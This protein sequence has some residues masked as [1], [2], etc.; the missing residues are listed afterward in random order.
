M[1]PIVITDRD[2]RIIR[3]NPAYTQMTGYTAEELIN[4]TPRLLRSGHHD[5]A[6][7]QKMWQQIKKEGHWQGEI[8]NRRKNGGIYVEWLT[9]AAVKDNAGEVTH[10]VASAH[11]LTEQK[12]I[13]AEIEKLAFYDPLT[14]LP[15]RRLLRDRLE[16]SLVSL[17][18]EK[19]SGAL[20]FIDLDNFKTI[21]D[22]MGHAVG[23][24]LLVQIAGRLREVTRKS[25]TVARLGGDEFVVLLTNLDIDPKVAKTQAQH[26]A[27][28]ILRT[29]SQPYTL[30]GRSHNS[31]PSIGISMF[32]DHNQD[33]DQLLKQADIAMYQAKDAGHGTIRFFDPQTQQRLEKQV[34]MELALRD[35][36]EQGRLSYQLQ[37]IVNT[38]GKIVAAELLARWLQ[39]DGSNIPPSE[40]IP[41]A[42]KTGLII[43][44]GKWVLE[45]ACQLLANWQHQDR[46]AD[47]TLSV[48]VSARQLQQ[49]SDGK[50]L[51]DLLDRTRAPAHRLRL[52]FT[53]SSMMLQQYDTAKIF[54][55]LRNL[56]IE[57]ALDDFGTGFSSL[58]HL[59]Q[60][61]VTQLKI[62]QSFVRDL[63]TDRND[64]AIVEAILA[65]AHALDLTV[66]A[67][68]VE[69]N[70]QF[71]FL[72]QHQCDL[73]QGY[74]F[75]RPMS[76]AEFE[77]LVSQESSC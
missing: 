14:G 18:R 36:L 48:N 44:L 70:E 38:A 10:Y 76:T 20:L 28:K 39:L 64:A 50:V 12:K 24:Q 61:P 37:P 53:E 9:I 65:M 52:E 66:V 71:N 69:T 77:A 51:Q 32:H 72:R 34:H 55:D 16:H 26:V 42:E 3:V 21:N 58:C 17:A 43:P 67:E 15:N 73:Y 27:E 40:F 1:Q 46:L 68:G 22:T 62:D 63:T 8:I 57:L 56:G 74:L 23:D 35:A 45:S 31:T 25:D 29:L 19:H 6:F 41:L 33:A 30:A 60:L 11:D 5:K 2:Q 75:Y 49:Y 13:Q 7:Y 54:F 59:K 47:I 4:N